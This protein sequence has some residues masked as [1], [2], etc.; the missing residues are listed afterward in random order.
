MPHDM[1]G[2]ACADSLGELLG[3]SYQPSLCNRLFPGL[4]LRDT[5]ADSDDVSASKPASLPF[6]PPHACTQ[7]RQL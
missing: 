5:A 6:D 1:E 3:S 4:R 2:K 7:G